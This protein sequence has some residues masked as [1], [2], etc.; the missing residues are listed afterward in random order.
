MSVRRVT[1]GF[2]LLEVLVSFIIV[3]VLM[4]SAMQAMSGNLFAE[5]NARDYQLAVLH[6][7]S[8]L[9]RLGNDLPLDSD[10]QGELAHDFTYEITLSDYQDPDS[11]Y[12]A[13]IENQLLLVHIVL[14]KADFEYELYTLRPKPLENQS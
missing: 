4:V 1:K 13:L 8:L 14:R 12:Q 9:A 6:G 7:Q 10:H 5:R 11:A 2:T 3:S